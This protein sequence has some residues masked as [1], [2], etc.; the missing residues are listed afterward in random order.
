[1]CL[2]RRLKKGIVY[3]CWCWMRIIGT[4]LNLFAVISSFM[5]DLFYWLD[6]DLLI[7]L[8]V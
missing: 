7:D 2:E 6:F 5:L 8:L 3:L 4:V 1:M